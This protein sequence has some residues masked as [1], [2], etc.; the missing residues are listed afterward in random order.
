MDAVRSPRQHAERGTSLDDLA[1][2]IE[3]PN[4]SPSICT[5][6]QPDPDL[7]IPHLGG[8]RLSGFLCGRAP[9]SEFPS[10]RPTGRT[11]AALTSCVRCGRSPT[12]GGG[13]GTDQPAS[14][15]HASVLNWLVARF[16]TSSV[17]DT[18]LDGGS[19]R[20][21]RVLSVGVAPSQS[22]NQFGTRWAAS[23]RVCGTGSNRSGKRCGSSAWRYRC[24]DHRP[25]VGAYRT[26]SRVRWKRRPSAF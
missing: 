21:N 22:A 7:V 5:R 9:A 17:R 11:S 25:S 10:V 3:P 14:L 16:A 1:S 13:S 23:Y 2:F 4:T 19:H 20:T 18:P 26:W 24:G 15:V 12:G 6:G 8:Q